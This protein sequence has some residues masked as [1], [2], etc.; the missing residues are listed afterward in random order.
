MTKFR[1]YD[2]KPCTIKCNCVEGSWVVVW[3]ESGKTRKKHFKSEAE[4]VKWHRDFGYEVEKKIVLVDSDRRTFRQLLPEVE[5]SDNALASPRYIKGQ[6]RIIELHL[7]P[8]FGEMYVDE[9]NLQSVKDFVDH[10]FM[11][12]FAQNTVNKEII[13]LRRILDQAIM[14]GY[15]RYNFAKRV[16]IG[17]KKKSMNYLMIEEVMKLV[18]LCDNCCSSGHNT[19]YGNNGDYSEGN[20]ESGPCVKPYGTF[21]FAMAF[22]GLRM[23]EATAL[24]FKHIDFARKIVRI[25]QAHGYTHNGNVF[26]KG[27][28]SK[29]GERYIPIPNVLFDRLEELSYG[30]E[31]D[32]YVFT[33][34]SGD[35]I[36]THFSNNQFKFL[37]KLAGFTGKAS[38]VTPHDLRH[39][40]AAILRNAEV[41]IT[42]LSKRMGHSS[43]RITDEWYNAFYDDGGVSY[44]DAINS[45]IDNNPDVIR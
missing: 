25:E 33:T 28:K 41:P 2:P 32:D 4:A 16:K 31:L 15:A 45:V 7:L 43:S 9:I 24:Q 44:L 10:Q 13:L 18:S 23:S 40:Y 20:Y 21:I 6:Q 19:G 12:G 17:Q 8:Y 37:K 5:V 30:K 34:V 42:E 14:L 38:E 3:K 39:T 35:T 22:L 1:L 36:R 27:T 26:L 29:A 11:K